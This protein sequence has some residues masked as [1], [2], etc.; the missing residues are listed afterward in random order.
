MHGRAVQFLDSAWRAAFL[1]TF[2]RLELGRERTFPKTILNIA[3]Q[4]YHQPGVNSCRTTLFHLGCTIC[5]SVLLTV[6]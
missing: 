4:K 5:L 6:P 2:F 3:E 1:D